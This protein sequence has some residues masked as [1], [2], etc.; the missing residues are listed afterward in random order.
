[1]T[2][3]DAYFRELN[4]YQDTAHFKNNITTTA[5]SVDNLMLQDKKDLH[6]AFK[7]IIIISKPLLIHLHTLV[8]NHRQDDYADLFAEMINKINDDVKTA[9][10]A[11][12]SLPE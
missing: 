4:D 7:T 10:T 9:N 12:P 2:A 11:L 5:G 6:L 8:D 1:L 3:Q